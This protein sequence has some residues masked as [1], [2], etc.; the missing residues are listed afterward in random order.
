MFRHA[1]LAACL[2]V[3]A[4][5]ASAKDAPKLEFSKDGNDLVVKTTITVN[6][7]SHV[8]WTDV[9]DG[10]DR[11]TLRY[12]VIQCKDLLVRSQK[13]ITIEWRVPAGRTEGVKYEMVDSFQPTTAQLKALLPQLEKLAAEGAKWKRDAELR[14]GDLESYERFRNPLPMKD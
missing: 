7:S 13:K 2:F 11:V 1:L 4:A 12:H 10:R 6:A 8:L 14:R 3:S 5:A 9:I